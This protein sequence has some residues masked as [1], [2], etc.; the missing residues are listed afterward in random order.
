MTTPAITHSVVL[1]ARQRPNAVGG[2]PPFSFIAKAIIPETPD[3]WEPDAF[4]EMVECLKA[5]AR[6]AGGTLGDF[7]CVRQPC[8]GLH[9]VTDDTCP[10]GALV[11]DWLI[12][13]ARQRRV[14]T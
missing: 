11:H 13:T 10:A 9:P 7:D 3:W 5:E 14:S 2:A 6:D 1:A 8:A 4:A 12:V